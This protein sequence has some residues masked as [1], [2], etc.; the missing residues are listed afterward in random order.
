MLLLIFF[1]WIPLHYWHEVVR[2]RLLLSHITVTLEI[3]N[4]TPKP[5]AV[6]WWRVHLT[7]SVERCGLET[8]P[9]TV[10]CSWA[11]LVTFTV[12][13]LTQEGKWNLVHHQGSLINA[14]GNPTYLLQSL[15]SWLI[16]FIIITLNFS[17]SLV[18]LKL[19][20]A[21]IY[22]NQQ[23]LVRIYSTF[24]KVTIY[25]IPVSFHIINACKVFH[26]LA[27]ILCQIKARLIFI[28]TLMKG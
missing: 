20:L 23:K 12:P 25:Y 4:T 19:L 17:P 18:K 1:C 14:W 21:R 11:K 5:C 24:A 3:K 9:G 27:C 22:I 13:L 28:F 16:Y 7:L 8:W 6:A 15:K 2:R 10:L 26:V